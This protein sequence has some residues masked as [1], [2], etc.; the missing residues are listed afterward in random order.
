MNAPLTRQ[1]FLL[2]YSSE[3]K[4]LRCRTHLGASLHAAALYALTE[5]GMIEDRDGRVHAT[6]TVRDAT[7]GC[8]LAADLFTRIRASERDRSWR[9]WIRKHERAAIGRVRDQL[10]RERL[11]KVEAHRVLGLVSSY[12]ITLREP[13]ERAAATGAMWDALKAT[14]P[15]DRVPAADAALA[16]FAYEG[17]LRVVLGGRERRL[18]KSRV[19]EFEQRLGPTPA[20]LRKVVRE[21]QSS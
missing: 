13:R 21:Q 4:R 14:T 19:R 18:A 1:L 3:H 10:A 9:H 2:A 6:G 7:R 16:V 8:D 11:I 17:E 15:S 20:A 12:R 5:D